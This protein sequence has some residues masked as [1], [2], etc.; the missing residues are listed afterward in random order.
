[1]YGRT[2]NYLKT[3]VLLGAALII[4]R[5]GGPFIVH[6]AMP[7]PPAKTMEE[8]NVE[9]R[10]FTN[11]YKRL[12][13]DL[14]GKPLYPSRSRYPATSLRAGSLR[15]IETREVRSSSVLTDRLLP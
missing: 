11:A 12:R 3:I 9:Y 10:T 13:E 14:Y 8:W 2:Q 15:S 7:E 4:T 5:Y 1:M 6:V